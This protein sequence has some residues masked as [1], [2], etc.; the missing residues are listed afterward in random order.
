[1]LNDDTIA[2]DPAR[3]N[4]KRHN[5]RAYSGNSSALVQGFVPASSRLR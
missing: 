3:R 4:I 5:E 1:M 2:I